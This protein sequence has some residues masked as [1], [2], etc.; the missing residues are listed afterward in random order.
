MAAGLPACEAA[1]V[2]TYLLCHRHAADECRFAHAAWRGFASPLRHRPALSSCEA[3]GHGLWWVVE[4]EDAP[5]ALSQLP[6]YVG[7]R[8]EAVCVKERVLP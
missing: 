8:T 3:G 7:E 2:P 4:A 5:A 1:P 6:E